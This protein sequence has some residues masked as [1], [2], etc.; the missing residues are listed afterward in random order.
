MSTH[1]FSHRRL[2]RGG[3]SGHAAPAALERQQTVV[4]RALSEARGAP[5]SYAQ[6]RDAGVEFPAS[7]VAEL[8]LAGVRV[9]RCYEHADGARMAVGVRLDREHAVA[10]AAEAPNAAGE[11][12]V[13][14]L[15]PLP[16]PTVA[17]SS[18]SW[19]AML[20]D[21]AYLRWLAA[22]AAVAGVAVVALLALIGLAGG[23]TSGGG[24]RA[25]ATRRVASSASRGAPRPGAA[26]PRRA[27]S[28]T[29]TPTPTP[30][31][32]LTHASARAVVSPA[33]AAQLEAQGHE[34]VQTGQYAQAIAVLRRAL[35]ATGASLT[36][37]V[38]P[39]GETCLTYAY[40][41]Y[42]LGRALR[43]NGSAAQAVGVLEHRL[44]IEN[45]RPVVAEE[46]ASARRQLG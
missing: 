35:A 3:V 11:C 38:Q 25:L 31:A 41:L 13:A 4:L 43:L 23:G 42:D 29:P 19:R 17:E 28:P 27:S 5:V 22:W 2:S 1:F 44:Q 18:R 16:A 30:E 37:C 15:K 36:S 33:L 46:L 6:L 7:V 20:S 12:A 39:T 32:S 34:M 9:E 21:R 26:G 24:E 40:A 8:E 45:Q 10:F 14:A